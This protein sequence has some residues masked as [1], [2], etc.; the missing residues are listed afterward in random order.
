MAL[1]VIRLDE[2]C[3][4]KKGQESIIRELTVPFEL[5]FSSIVNLLGFRFPLTKEERAATKLPLEITMKGKKNKDVK[6]DL[7][8]TIFITE[9][10][11]NGSLESIAKDYLKANG[12]GIANMNPTIRSK[13]LFGVASTMAKI[14]ETGVIHRDLKL[15][16]VFF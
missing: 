4:T 14:H 5:N 16:N 2:S 12:K 11:H 1:K 13:I 3:S 7:G 9:Y 10:M 8:G 6:V 15:E